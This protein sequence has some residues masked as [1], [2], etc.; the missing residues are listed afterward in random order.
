MVMRGA[1]G[2]GEAARLVPG[3]TARL[4][5]DRSRL[6]SFT[7]RMPEKLKASMDGSGF[8]SNLCG[9]ENRN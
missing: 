7:T 8:R 1:W 5:G 9:E 4:T 6:N 3:G 2:L